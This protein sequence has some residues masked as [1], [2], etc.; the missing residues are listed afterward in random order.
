MHEDYI[1]T[2][3]IIIYTYILHGIKINKENKQEKGRKKSL[4]YFTNR[5][6]ICNEFFHTVV[7]SLMYTYLV[8][9]YIFILM[10]E[11]TLRGEQIREYTLSGDQID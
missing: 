4:I 9:D 2:Y 5:R 8:G 7:F 1:Y 11:Y 10:R 6:N 3:Y